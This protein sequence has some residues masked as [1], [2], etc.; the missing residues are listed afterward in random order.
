MKTRVIS[1]LLL[2]AMLVTAV[3]LAAFS[4]LAAD[5]E[6][7][8][9]P[10][11]VEY[12]EAD[13]NALYKQEGLIFAF[14]IMQANS[15][16]GGTYK[17]TL[18]LTVYEDPQ[19]ADMNFQGYNVKCVDTKNAVTWPAASLSFATAELAAAKARELAVTKVKDLADAKATALSVTAVAGDDGSYTV[20]QDETT[21]YLYKLVEDNGTFLVK[22]IK[23]VTE[24]ETPTVTETVSFTY[25]VVNDMSAEAKTAATTYFSA[26]KAW[27]EANTWANPKVNK[28]Y[29][30]IQSYNPASS[31]NPTS[32]FRDIQLIL[33]VYTVEAG[34]LQVRD[35]ISDDGGLSVFNASGTS[36]ATNSMSRQ[37]TAT[38][39]TRISKAYNLFYNIRP[40]KLTIDKTAGTMY[41]GGLVDMA[42]NKSGAMMV[43]G[44]FPAMRP[45]S[46]VTPASITYTL[47]GG[48]D[49][50]NATYM[51]RDQNGKILEVSGT[52]RPGSVSANTLNGTNRLNYGDSSRGTKLY[53]WRDY[54]VALSDTDLAQNHFADIAKWYKLDLSYISLLEGDEL[55]PVYEAAKPFTVDADNRDAIVAAVEGAARTAA[56][57]K[58]AGVVATDLLAVISAYGLDAEPFTIFPHYMLPTAYALVV[59]GY[60][61]CA[62]ADEVKAEY[63]AALAADYKA[64]G[65]AYGTSADVYNALY[66]ALDDARY[67]VDFFTLNEL[68]GEEFDLPDPPYT[69]DNYK[70]N[71]VPYDFTDPDNR[72]VLPD[73]PYAVKYS[74][75]NYWYRTSSGSITYA[76]GPR[77]TFATEE[78]A[79]AFADAVKAAQNKAATVEKLGRY[80]VER[81]NLAHTSY[82]NYDTAGSFGGATSMRY[83]TFEEAD[84]KARELAGANAIQQADGSW[85]AGN[86]DYKP[87]W[88][89]MVND[90]YQGAVDAYCLEIRDLIESFA[91]TDKT[92]TLHFNQYLP[93][94]GPRG[95]QSLDGGVALRSGLEPGDGFL[96]HNTVN[97]NSYLT[98]SGA[99][100]TGT[101]VADFLMSGGTK[102]IKDAALF[103]IRDAG[104]AFTVNSSGTQL[105]GINSYGSFPNVDFSHTVADR[106]APFHLSIS[107]T[108]ALPNQTITV[109]VNGTQVHTGT[110]KDGNG[111]VS[112][113]LMLGWSQATAATPRY[114]T[115]RFFNRALTAA[116]QAPPH[117]VDLAK[118]FRLDLSGYAEAVKKGADLS[119]LYAVAAD[120]TVESGDRATL[121][122]AV[123]AVLYDLAPEA[124][125]GEYDTYLEKGF[126]ADEVATAR[127]FGLR[128]DSMDML[129]ALPRAAFPTA[130]ATYATLGVEKLTAP[131]FA[132]AADRLA[133]AI[134]ADIAASGDAVF[135]GSEY[136]A[137]YV[138]DKLVYAL[139]FAST[140][141]YWSNTPEGGT[142]TTKEA[143]AAIA[144]H[145]WVGTRGFSIAFRNSATTA[146]V[147]I[148]DGYLDLAPFNNMTLSDL[149]ID[150]ANGRNGATVEEV[151]NYTGTSTA[152]IG[153]F[154]GVRSYV[155]PTTNTLTSINTG[156]IAA[157][158]TVASGLNVKFDDISKV[159]TFTSTFYRPYPDMNRDATSLYHTWRDARITEDVYKALSVDG[160]GDGT[161][162][163][164]VDLDT[165]VYTPSKHASDSGQIWSRNHPLYQVTPAYVKQGGEY[166]PNDGGV[167]YYVA[168]EPATV[169]GTWAM[170]Q[171]GALRYENNSASYKNTDYYDNHHYTI[172]SG[173]GSS[174]TDGAKVYFLRYYAKKLTP[175]EQAQNHFADIAKFFR[176][177]IAQYTALT[178]E[179]RTLVDNE[180][181]GYTVTD[182]RTAVLAGYQKALLEVYK[183]VCDRLAEEQSALHAEYPNLFAT[184]AEYRLPIEQFLSAGR[185]MS[186][187]YGI[188]SDGETVN[189]MSWAAAAEFVAELYHDTYYYRSYWR[190][191]EESGEGTFNGL[192]TALMASK[193]HLDAELL[194]ALPH[195]DRMAFAEGGELSQDAID[196]FVAER[197]TLYGA[198]GLVP[199]DYD[200]L[201]VQ[202][203]LVYAIDFFKTNRYWNLDGKDYSVPVG[204]SYDSR[205]WHDTNGN[206]LAESSEMLLD[207]VFQNGAEKNKYTQEF[208]D[209]VNAWTAADA[210]WMTQF[211]TVKSDVAARSYRYDYYTD[212]KFDGNADKYTAY[213]A[214]KFFPFYTAG[215][216]YIQFRTDGHTSGG[217]IFLDMAKYVSDNMSQQ[218]VAEVSGYMADNFTIFYDVRPDITKTDTSLKFDGLVGGYHFKTEETLKSDILTLDGSAIDLTMTLTNVAAKAGNNSVIFSTEDGKLAEFSGTYGKADKSG[219]WSYTP[220]DTQ[221][222]GWSGNYGGKLYA[223]RYYNEEL[224]QDEILTNHFADLAKFFRLE[225]APYNRL[226]DAERA[227]VH[228][229][230]KDYDL[231]TSTREEVQ[232]AYSIAV[233]GNDYDEARAKGA[234]PEAFLAIAEE[235]LI[236]IEPLLAIREDASRVALT[237]AVTKDFALGY[238]LNASVID[239]V[240]KQEMAFLDALTFLGMSVRIHTGYDAVDMPGVRAQFVVDDALLAEA[241]ITAFGVEILNASGNVRATLTFN[242]ETLKGTSVVTGK[243]PTEAKINVGEKAGTHEF[244]YTVIYSAAGVQT[245]KY[246]NAEM[247]YRFFVVKGEKTYTRDIMTSF[248]P[249]VSA[250]EVYTYFY[251]NAE[252]YKLVDEEG[253]IDSVVTAV[254]ETLNP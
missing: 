113:N 79:L 213:Y 44:E 75:D 120:Y 167:S 60:R 196:A 138:Q 6:A 29:L 56:E 86:Y 193:P 183:Q 211:K 73:K 153:Q 126:T 50:T 39:G 33:S 177:D 103:H 34:Y 51:L 198:S 182:D 184:V 137:L 146:A 188:M 245:A 130:W 66:A 225:I 109:G 204:P 102:D 141:E 83:A 163:V 118:F 197:M 27:L 226:T 220:S 26:E 35:D 18:P 227:A 143:N 32:R 185:D 218:L 191:G 88:E 154:M 70:Y 217:L 72:L 107:T 111:S 94:I 52:Y 7:G 136:N 23:T 248:G 189:A 209:A 31:G 166:V 244:A 67:A 82:T 108:T 46:V 229:A 175:A 41:F 199:E 129:A 114:Y 170:Y 123:T 186:Y 157:F 235:L 57:N 122:K 119:A 65:D 124:Y 1:T 80:I 202:D 179:Q 233:Y 76:A 165:V 25:T 181:Q 206:G 168:V 106:Y 247:G 97:S 15:H 85:R 54:N 59:N 151:R 158:N 159:A 64:M 180:M 219:N 232:K 205:F 171:N 125:R 49:R 134:T 4:V 156:G 2:L 240:L 228:L 45:V 99:G 105:T 139:D 215:D 234:L 117:F 200:S 155:S 100:T 140:N 252:Q 190:D 224:T 149:E 87:M 38:L 231:A 13:Y 17:G 148:K 192:L 127:L 21:V 62:D 135:S 81:F 187:A 22:E 78:E 237:A 42:E 250:A 208:V 61:E 160:N 115:F 19:Y 93:S 58:Y 145:R 110:H 172:L 40:D 238:S 20:M 210:A 112:A 121:Q 144:E 230:M 161:P 194:M 243:E 98:S 77:T 236:D 53:A 47:N 95:H 91:E 14:D 242:A 251:K 150:L 203:G 24:A 164:V 239:Y 8:E 216:G 162:D 63:E 131:D 254:Y 214:S 195:S 37:F 116:E 36:F 142:Y 221:Y 241:G 223:Y 128:L 178:A 5:L 207:K 173:G 104:Y 152:L 55:L 92:P 3:P 12:T 90:A 69:W 212:A 174:A 74:G 96:I 89:P 169:T 201:Y 133:A 222:L 11:G 101:L 30:Y 132:G 84:A 71:G 246:Y 68:W 28:N 176:L 43:T 249:T 10:A 9:A 16:W 253:K 48:L 147:T